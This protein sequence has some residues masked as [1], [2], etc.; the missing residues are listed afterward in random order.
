M[1][2]VKRQPFVLVSA[3]LT[4]S[5][6]IAT[7]P[8]PTTPAQPAAAP[9]VLSTSLPTI[10]DDFSVLAATDDLIWVRLP[11]D[12]DQ[13]RTSLS[14]DGGRTWT[15][16][17]TMP[18]YGH[19]TAGAGRLAY[20]GGDDG[21]G[22]PYYLYPTDLDN[23]DW[24]ELW[25]VAAM[26]TKATL[27]T[28][29]RLVRAGR[30][31]AAITFAALPKSATKPSHRYA[32][33]SDSSYVVRISTTQGSSDYASV[34]DV[35]RAKSVGRLI[36]PRTSQHRVSGSALYSLTSSKS[37][38]R[39]CRQPLPSG[40][41]SCL[42]VAGGDDRKKA[43]ALYQFGENSVV[44]DPASAT[45]L[46]V[47]AGRV[48]PIVLPA[49]TVSWTAEGFGDPT[50]PLLRTLDAAGQPH[51]VRVS[52]DG[53]TIEYRAVPRVPV[54]V[55]SLALGPTELFGSHWDENADEVNWRRVVGTTGLGS[56]S[57]AVGRV[58][59]VSGSRRA[60]TGSSDRTHLYDGDRRGVPADDI[61][62]L[63]G[64]YL[65]SGDDVSLVTGKKLATSGAEALFGSLVAEHIKTPKGQN[66]YWLSVRD[67]AAPSAVPVKIRLIGSSSLLSPVYMWG[68]WLGTGTSDGNA[69]VVNRRTGQVLTRHVGLV[70]LGDGFAVVDDENYSLSIWQF[71]TNKL[72]RLDKGS[73]SLLF[74]A[75]GNKVA[76][77]DTKR[78]LVRTVPGAGL[79]RPRL[80]G[81]LTSG[82]ATRES[83]WDTAIDL[84]K[85]VTAGS[86]VIRDRAG[87]VVR[88]LAT[89]PSPTGSIRGISWTGRDATGKQLKGT[90]T[91]ELIAAATDG[92]G[93]AGSVSGDGPAKGTITAG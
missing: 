64:P 43:A 23:G 58:R 91:W 3:L 16:L 14:K 24:G 85:A 34:V 29:G 9:T 39:L 53:S 56:P 37:A 59:V 72:T 1:I 19:E 33:T 50:R 40:A 60:V 82:K 5:L 31:N 81:A 35:A 80:L 86:L 32:F 67:L 89:P 46:L 75:Y 47:E 63:T 66:G 18:E 26:A 87:R 21:L 73:S 92:S 76:Y 74:D 93:F 79:S 44:R 38:A 84:T 69:R 12:Y 15:K 8:R 83:P 62:T 41:A 48:T 52:A 22:V 54:D 45:P 36:L 30:A 42:K 71:A 11:A 90:F 10:P 70:H 68:D 4:M 27:A 51:H 6:M 13:N 57:P 78:L 25:N 65:L 28:N 77:T 2:A 49:G 17:G 61:W 20:F 88:T 7:I 55:W